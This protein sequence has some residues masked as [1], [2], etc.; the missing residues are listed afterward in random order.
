MLKVLGTK[1]SKQLRIYLIDY[2]TEIFGIAFKVQPVT[3][4]DKHP[5]LVLFVYKLLVSFV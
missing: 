3:F 2:P 1:Q 4:N 5:A